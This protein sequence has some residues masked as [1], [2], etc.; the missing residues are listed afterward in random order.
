MPRVLIDANVL[1]PT[2]MRELVLGVARQGLFV[3]LWSERILEEWRLAAAKLGPEGILQAEA[4]IALLRRDWPGAVIPANPKTSRKLWLP[5]PDDIHVLAAAVDGEA[6]L[7]MT[8]NARDFPVRILGESGILRVDPDTHLRDLWNDAPEAI[9]FVADA[10]LAEA[11]RLS[12][13]DWTMR[14]LL[15]KARMPQLGKALWGR[16]PGGDQSSQRS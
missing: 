6:Q 2:V 16:A 15:K 1:Y 11:R 8:R 7:I 13:R 12:G 5:D 14:E 4:E 3:P 10:V 9:E